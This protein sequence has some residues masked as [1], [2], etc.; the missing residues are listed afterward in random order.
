LGGGDSLEQRRRRRPAPRPARVARAF[1]EW[2]VLGARCVRSRAYLFFMRVCLFRS[3]S[4]PLS[5]LAGQAS[6][7]TTPRPFLPSEPTGAG[8]SFATLKPVL[9]PF[10]LRAE[11]PTRA[12]A[13]AATAIA[14]YPSAAL[15]HD[16]PLPRPWA[17]CKTAQASRSPP[18]RSSRTTPSDRTAPRPLGCRISPDRPLLPGRSQPPRLSQA[19]KRRSINYTPR[20]PS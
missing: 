19:S 10:I 5:G 6:Q 13:A 20:R 1:S 9:C 18:H 16:R 14:S 8:L 11:S 17:R 12:R 7:R 3:P 4:S 2:L 15:A